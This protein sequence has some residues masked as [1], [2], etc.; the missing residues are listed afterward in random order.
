MKSVL[1]SIL[2]LSL[3]TGCGYKLQTRADL[4]FESIAIGDIKNLTYEPRLQD[5]MLSILTETLRTY[6][7]YIDNTARYRIEGEIKGFNMRVLSE[8]G[9]TATEYEVDIAVSFK[10]IDRE[11]GKAYPIRL[12]K[13]FPTHFTTKERLSEVL[14]QKEDYTKKALGEIAQEISRY[15]I[16]DLSKY[17]AT[18]R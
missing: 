9:L 18:M 14:V 1:I 6:G 13:P 16:Y 7:F 11:T 4:P 12:L 17:R 5:R 15:L 10:I 2:A 3:L 8:K